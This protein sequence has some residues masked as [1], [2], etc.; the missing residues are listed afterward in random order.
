M[1]RDLTTPHNNLALT[2]L[3]CIVI[4]V[5]LLS[6]TRAGFVVTD[7]GW[8]WLILGTPWICWA[9]AHLISALVWQYTVRVCRLRLSRGVVVEHI[10]Q[11]VGQL[12]AV[13]R[14]PRWWD[15]FPRWPIC[16]ELIATA[17]G[18]EPLVVMPARLRKAVV[19]TLEAALPGA[20]LDD[21]TP[22]TPTYRCRWIKAGELRLRGTGQQ[23]LAVERGEETSRH[24]LASLQPLHSGEVVRVQWLIVRGT[25]PP[26]PTQPSGRHRIACSRPGS[27]TGECALATDRPGT[28]RRVSH[29]GLH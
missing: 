23:L 20:R 28:Q 15:V 14:A 4:I 13:L 17:H 18:V 16:I 21:K 27:A 8:V 5:T 9:L 7:W 29:R 25:C 6:A 10:S 12:A 3:T 19:A 22:T 26:P 11:W 2:L 1:R 24:V